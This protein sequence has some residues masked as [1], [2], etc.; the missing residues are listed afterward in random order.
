MY[1]PNIKFEPIA[2]WRTKINIICSLPDT[3]CI[4]HYA[5]HPYWS[6][7]PPPPFVFLR[8][9]PKKRRASCKHRFIYKKTSQEQ[10]DQEFI[11]QK[12]TT[13]RYFHSSWYQMYLVPALP[14]PH[15]NEPGCWCL[16]Q[17]PTLFSKPKALP[18]RKFTPHHP[19]PST[20]HPNRTK[21]RIPRTLGQMIIVQRNE[22]NTS[23]R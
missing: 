18:P 11:V 4:L 23:E 13:S 21:S 20:A 12:P 9:G 8:A 6:L 5:H 3:Y 10:F 17:I 2:I 15:N 16:S 19:Y 14:I 1:L 7:P 22:K